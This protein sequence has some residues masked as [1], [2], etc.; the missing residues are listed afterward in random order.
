MNEEQEIVTI[1]DQQNNEQIEYVRQLQ[2]IADF[3]ILKKKLRW[4]GIGGVFFGGLILIGYLFR[5]GNILEFTLID[6]IT[7]IL[8]GVLF[9]KGW[10]LLK[11]PRPS[12]L[13]FEGVLLLVVSVFTIIW[14]ALDMPEGTVEDPVAIVPIFQVV[15]GIISRP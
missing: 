9:F 5:L 4:G 7:V 10:R 8:G 2:R 1:T 11:N 15:W 12:D 14:M 13:V 6:I 3:L